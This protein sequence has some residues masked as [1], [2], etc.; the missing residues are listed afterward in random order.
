VTWQP[1][2]EHASQRLTGRGVP[3]QEAARLLWSSSLA[4]FEQHRGAEPA[5]AP[6]G[7]ADGAPEPL[8]YTD[9]QGPMF[10]HAHAT[11]PGPSPGLR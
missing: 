6:Q 3:N 9:R 11:C 4:F 1:R 7:G 8:C 2:A 10:L 5:R